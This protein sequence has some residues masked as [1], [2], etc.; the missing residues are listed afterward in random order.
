MKNMRLMIWF[1]IHSN[2]FRDGSGK[3]IQQKYLKKYL[4]KNSK[5]KI[6]DQIQQFFLTRKSPKYRWSQS[7]EIEIEIIP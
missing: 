5:L 7:I 6:D 4:R 1:A 2:L 3:L